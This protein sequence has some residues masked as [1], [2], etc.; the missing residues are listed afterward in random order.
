[1]RSPVM[2]TREGLTM[3][4]APPTWRRKSAARSGWKALRWRSDSCT[5]HTTDLGSPSTSTTRRRSPRMGAAPASTPSS[6]T[7][8]KKRARGYARRRGGARAAI[9][10]VRRALASWGSLQAGGRT[11]TGGFVRLLPFFSHFFGV[12]LAPLDNF[13]AIDD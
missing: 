7:G 8:R 6:A 1:M 12:G 4:R 11:A 2:R 5:A 13:Q 10:G 9:V 3:A